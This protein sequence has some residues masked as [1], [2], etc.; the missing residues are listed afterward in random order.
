MKG[1]IFQMKNYGEITLF[2]FLDM[3]YS[4]LVKKDK[5][6]SQPA[7]QNPQDLHIPEDFE[8][9]PVLGDFPPDGDNIVGHL[10]TIDGQEYIIFT[11][12][13]AFEQW[14]QVNIS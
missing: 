8:E 10:V 1:S 7:E 14:K 13:E 5:D 12:D 6:I 9:Y 3:C 2:S 4:R 11:D